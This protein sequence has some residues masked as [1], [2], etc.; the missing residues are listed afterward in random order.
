MNIRIIFV[1]LL[2]AALLSA[3][4]S[5]TPAD[6]RPEVA[7]PLNEALHLSGYWTPDK[8]AIM[9][10]LDQAASVP[11]LNSGEQN[12]IR[13]TAAVALAKL[14]PNG[15]RMLPGDYS[16]RSPSTQPDYPQSLGF[17]GL[18]YGN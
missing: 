10:K 2:S 18:N 3:C 1:T 14:P 16:D 7:Q 5:A 9:A 4:S 6:I 17:K 15:S 13:A 8:A 11:N 12:Q